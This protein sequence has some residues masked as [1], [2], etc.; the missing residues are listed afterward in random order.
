MPEV[1]LIDGLAFFAD[2][3]ADS[4]DDARTDWTGYVVI[5]VDV[6]RLPGGDE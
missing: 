2:L 6:V 1:L 4:D 5:P 3:L